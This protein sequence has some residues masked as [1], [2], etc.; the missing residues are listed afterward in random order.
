MLLNG[1]RKCWTNSPHLH[2]FPSISPAEKEVYEHS[3]PLGT[4]QL[5]HEFCSEHSWPGCDLSHEDSFTDTHR[6]ILSI[7]KDQLKINNN[8][9]NK[10]S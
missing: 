9:S 3:Q 4:D 6:H 8:L 5:F 2:R 10:F 1:Q 7:V